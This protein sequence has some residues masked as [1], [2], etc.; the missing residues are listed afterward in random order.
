VLAIPI[1]E[2]IFL[3][4]KSLIEKVANRS[5]SDSEWEVAKSD[6]RKFIAEFLGTKTQLIEKIFSKISDSEIK[7]LQKYRLIQELIDF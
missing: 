5:F 2:V 4:Q 1:I 3:A 6:P 7:S